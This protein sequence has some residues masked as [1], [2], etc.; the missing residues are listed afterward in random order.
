[1]T[2]D[3][4]TYN[5]MYLKDIVKNMPKNMS[6]IHKKMYLQNCIKVYN[7]S[8]IKYNCQEQILLQRTNFIIIKTYLNL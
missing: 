6:L 5:G 3:K 4:I 8:K 7:L 1:M 2:R